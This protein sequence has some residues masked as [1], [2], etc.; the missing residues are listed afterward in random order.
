MPWTPADAK[1]HKKGLSPKQAR[2][3][4]AVAN[5]VQKAC[6]ADGGSAA[7]CD[8]KAIRQANG[9]VGP[10]A[11]HAQIPQLWTHTALI[12]HPQHVLLHHRDYLTAPVVMLVAGVLNEGLVTGEALDPLAWNGVPVVVNHPCNVT[13]N[14]VSARSPEVLEDYGIGHIYNA[15]L[16]TGKR[17]GQA[18]PSLVAE[19]WIDVERVKAL[20]GEALQA[21]QMLETHTPLE[22][23]TAFYSD[24]ERQAGSF[25]GTP[26]REIHHNLR[27]D[28]LA[29]LPNTIGACSVAHG[30]G[31]PR[32]NHQACAC[33]DPAACACAQEDVPMVESQPRGWRGFVQM[34]RDF[35]THEETPPPVP[36]EADDEDDAPPPTEPDDDEDEEDEDDKE[37]VAADLHAQRTDSDMRQALEGCLV[38]EMGRDV[39]YFHISHVDPETQSFIYQSG[40]RLLRRYWTLVDNVVTLQPEREEVQPETTFMTIPDTAT[41]AAPTTEE[42]TPMPQAVPNVYLKSHVNWLIANSVQTGWTEDDR[43]ILEAMTEPALIRLRNL[44]KSQPPPQAHEPTTM[45]EALELVPAQFR[46]TLSNATLAYQRHKTKLVDLL[47]NHAQNPFAKD[48][49]EGMTSERLEQLVVM[50]GEEIPDSHPRTNQQHQSYAGRRIPQ[51]RVVQDED[52]QPPPPPKTMDL[53]VQ[54]Q[55]ELGLRA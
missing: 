40:T 55:R 37:R 18:V 53:V 26:Y 28:H 46:E 17:N 39:G 12:T 32:L 22:V 47:V 16:G 13:G 51:L 10:P 9:V 41:Q 31:A 38:R 5:S 24:A 42:Y 44:P 19:L 30:C 27:P 54:R 35:V 48:E 21:Y 7:E 4:A 34:L 2:Q 43:H 49:L 1:R 11:R 8:A 3:W 23:S 36:P 29:L 50:A 15:R 20:G 52:D 33:A 45:A 14:A 25:Y 6:L